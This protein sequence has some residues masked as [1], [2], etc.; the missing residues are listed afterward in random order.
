MHDAKGRQLKVGDLVLIPAEVIELS[1]TPDYCNVSV[2]SRLGRRPDGLKERV[3]AI[4]TGVLLRANP[5]DENELG[6]LAT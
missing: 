5:G 6:E 2:Q 4:N 3:S 1:S